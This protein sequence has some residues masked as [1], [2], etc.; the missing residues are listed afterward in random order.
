MKHIFPV[1]RAK[2]RAAAGSLRRAA[3]L[4]LVLLLALFAVACSS[5]KASMKSPEL[6]PRHWLDEAPGVPVE[7]KDKLEAVV[8]NLY[9]PDKQ[10]SF[11]ELVFLTIQQSPLLVNSAVDLEINRL[12]RT[13]AGWKYLPEPRMVL[14]VSNNITRYNMNVRNTPSDYGRPRLRAS[15]YAPFPNPVATYF[16]NKVQQGLVNVAIS[17]H[18]KAV[19]DVIYEMAQSYLKLEARRR[20]LAAQKGILPLGTNLVQY[21]QQVEAVDGRQGTS[22]DMARQSQRERELN[23][24]KSTQ[25][26]TIDRTRIKLIAGVEPEQRLRVDPGSADDILEGFDG[27]TLKW[28]DRWAMTED[29]LLLRAQLKLSDYNIM[30]AWAQYVPNISFYVNDSP[31]AGQYQPPNGKDDYFLHV[32]FDFPLID[33]GRRYRDVQTARMKKAQAFHDIARR[34]TEYS[35]NWLQAEQRVTLAETDLKVQKIR[36]ETAE[37]KYKEARIAFDEGTVE[38]PQVVE[39]EEAAA[40]ARIAYIR[41]ELEYNL[42]RLEW[43][44]I[45]NLLQERFLGPP[46]KE[47]I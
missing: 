6:P 47:I 33:W 25:E 1:S 5:S 41:A 22:L 34:R 14:T 40:N 32:N 36:L 38:L 2:G 19:G 23:V 15:F 28:E 27:H 4:L 10:F 46:A 35:Y 42:A 16:E 7:N 8:P 24:E 30:L 43:M 31:P 44:Y 17:T 39:G 9:D 21:W 12:A 11:E 37:M 29:E 20:I 18:R 45:A 13:N 26:E 3:P